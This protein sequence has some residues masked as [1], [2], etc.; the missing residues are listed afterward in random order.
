MLDEP[1]DAVFDLL[2]LLGLLFVGRRDILNLVGDERK[3]RACLSVAG[4]LD[5]GVER[6]K[7]VW[8]AMS[9][10]TSTTS[11]MFSGSVETPCMNR[12]FTPSISDTL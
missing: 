9:L 12:Q 3:A 11:S 2:N 7:F 4:G 1:T 10:I 6:H 8:P 5:R